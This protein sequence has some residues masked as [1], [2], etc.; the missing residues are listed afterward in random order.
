[1]KRFI[2]ILAISLIA[3][4]PLSALSVKS[5][6]EVDQVVDHDYFIVGYDEETECPLYVEYTL[7]T[8]ETSKLGSVPRKDHFRSDKDVITGSATK[9]DYNNSGF[10]RGHLFPFYHA[11]FN[12]EA[13]DLSFLMSN[14]C[15]QYGSM[16]RGSWKKHEFYIIDIAKEYG[17]VDRVCGPIFYNNV[18]ARYIGKNQVRVPDSFY[19]IISYMK[20]GEEVIECI[21][22]TN[23]STADEVLT[24]EVTIQ[25]IEEL[26]GIIFEE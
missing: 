16:N 14:M 7:D 24:S 3:L 5:C 10:D 8:E 13:G 19:S 2:S 23:G 6:D 21:I 18:P 11:S 22:M 4:T 25:D 1:M 17:D 9:D 15:P 12:A 26:T 20:D